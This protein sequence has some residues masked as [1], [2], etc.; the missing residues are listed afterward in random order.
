MLLSWVFQ[1]SYRQAMLRMDEQVQTNDEQSQPRSQ[2]RTNRPSK[3]NHT[4][5]TK[6]EVKKPKPNFYT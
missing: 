4:S 6:K 5:K 3:M 2:A 1:V